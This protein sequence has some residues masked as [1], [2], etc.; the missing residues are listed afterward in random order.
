MK[1]HGGVV[2]PA[3]G[4]FRVHRLPRYDIIRCSTAF[5][6]EKRNEHEHLNS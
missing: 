3:M 6:K 1:S 2:M 5:I 4:L